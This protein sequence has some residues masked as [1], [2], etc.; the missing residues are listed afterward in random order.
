MTD[1]QKLMGIM[2]KLA[3]SRWMTLRHTHN[4]HFM[5]LGPGDEWEKYKSLHDAEFEEIRLLRIYLGLNDERSTVYRREQ[6]R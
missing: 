2:E 4:R 3:S 6:C 1:E 5:T